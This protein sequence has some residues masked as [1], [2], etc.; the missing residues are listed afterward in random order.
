MSCYS[1]LFRSFKSIRLIVYLW[2]EPPQPARLPSQ[3]RGWCSKP[4]SHWLSSTSCPLSSCMPIFIFD[5]CLCWFNSDYT[6]CNI[7]VKTLD[8][9]G[10]LVLSLLSKVFHHQP[11][12]I[13]PADHYKPAISFTIDFC[14]W[15]RKEKKWSWKKTFMWML[16]SFLGVKGKVNL[17]ENLSVDAEKFSRSK[18]K[19]KLTENLSED[20]RKFS[21]S[22]RKR[23]FERKPFWRCEKVSALFHP[24]CWVSFVQPLDLHKLPKSAGR[25][26]LL[27]EICEF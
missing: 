24:W 19:W 20:D 6:A 10:L 25:L 8:D 13:P 2:V 1:I 18:G 15:R 17:K 11:V 3:C 12:H 27:L 22:K 23:E 14:S 5:Y 9:T 21:K 4:R 26:E 16:K 7:D